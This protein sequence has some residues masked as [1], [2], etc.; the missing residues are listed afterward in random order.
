MLDS[1]GHLILWIGPKVY[2]GLAGGAAHG[3]VQFIV[4]EVFDKVY[5]LGQFFRLFVMLACV[6]DRDGGAEPLTGFDLEISIAFAEIEF[7]DLS[8]TGLGG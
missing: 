2:D 4:R 1:H 7:A 8:V 6:N 5:F 3:Q